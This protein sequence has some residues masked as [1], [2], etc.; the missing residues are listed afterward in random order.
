M[1]IGRE[2]YLNMDEVKQLRTVTEARSLV[3]LAYGRSGGVKSWMLVDM[4]LATGLRVAELASIQISDFDAKRGALT[5][6]RG[7]RIIKKPETMPIRP[8]LVKHLIEYTSWLNR[9]EGSLFGVKA[10]ALQKAWKTAVKRAGLPPELSIHSA[11]HTFGTQHYAKEKNVIATQRLL[12]HAS[13]VT[14][15]NMYVGVTFEDLQDSM[16]GMYED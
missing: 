13:P 1:T 4:A 14:T 12:G 2:K 16:K 5:V 7:K 10:Q 11:R 9:K 3:D 8:E 15:A 6:T